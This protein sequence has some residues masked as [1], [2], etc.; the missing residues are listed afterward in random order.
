MVAHLAANAFAMVLLF[1]FHSKF[2]RSRLFKRLKHKLE[3]KVKTNANV[4][5][6][7]IPTC[8]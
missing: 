2:A 3:G 7:S 8:G 5:W 1:Y 4:S 6:K